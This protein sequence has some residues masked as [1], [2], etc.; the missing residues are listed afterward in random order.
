LE[1]VVK[2]AVVTGGSS[3]IGAAVVARLV[4]EGYAVTDLSRSSGWDVT[5]PTALNKGMPLGPVDAWVLCAG[6]VDPAP[7]KA[8]TR[9]Q[10]GR[11]LAVNVGHQFDVIS[12]IARS[13]VTHGPVVIVASTAGTRSSPG[14]AT[15]AAA[16]AALINL[17]LTAST[18][19][20]ATRTR[21]YV[22]APG[23]CATALRARL[24][25]D[26]DPST[27]MQPAEVAEVVWTCINDATGVLSGQVIEVKRRW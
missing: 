20:A 6:E 3:G 4:S 23:R 10:W 2:R 19:L 24:A 9:E 5:D 22:L 8:A 18:E 16:K 13:G 11:S 12:R 1:V 21:V 15:Y 27:I 14:W 26:E 17:G 7:L 25:P